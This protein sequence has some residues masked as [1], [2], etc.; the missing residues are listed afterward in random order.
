[1]DEQ[2]AELLLEKTFKSSFDSDNF[3]LF[4]KELFNKFD[5]SK[6]DAE[7]EEIPKDFQE[8]IESYS[9][10]G[11][12][13][14]Q[15]K[16]F[17][18][19][20]AVKLKK[21]NPE[22]ARTMQRNFVAKYLEHRNANAALVAFYGDEIDNWRFSFVKLEYHLEK[23]EKGNVKP[24][25]SLTPPKRYSFLVGKTESSHT[26]QS[27]FLELLMKE[28]SSLTVSE[29][30][31]SFSVEKVT[32]EFFEKYKELFLE[33]E[34][35]LNK[36]VKQNKDLAREFNE[37]GIS[38]IDFTKK[39]LGQI[40]FIYFLQKKGWLG[41]EKDETGKFRE[42]GTG[43]KDFLKKLYNKNIVSYNNFFNDI[44]EPLFYEALARDRSIDDDYYGKFRCKIPFLNG[45][46]FE[47]VGGYNW[48]DTDILLDN[49]IFGRIIEIFDLYNFTVKEDEPLEKEVAI[50]PEM[51]G[52]VFENLLEVKDRKSKGSYYTPREIVYYM[53]QE[54]LINY[55][56]TKTEIDKKHIEDFI[57]NGEV[58][59]QIRDAKEKVDLSLKN[60]KVVDPA[61]G[62][63]AFP[64]GMMMEIIKA[65]GVLT[66]LFPKEEQFERTA[67]NFKRECIE[68]NLYG[69]DIDP[70][71]VDIAQLRL[72]LSLIV[73]E[74]DI[75][76]IKPLPNLD[77]KIM[78]GNS[79]LDEFEGVKLFDERL[80]GEIKKE[81]YSEEIRKIEKDIGK[82][83]EELGMIA[84]G[85]KKDY[86]MSKG[87]KREIDKLKKKKQKLM[88]TPQKEGVNRDL[89]EIKKIKE[90]QKKL[91]EIKE[92][93]KL[94]FNEHDRQK[95]IELRKEIEKRD[96]E[97]IEETLKE[98]GNEDAMKKLEQVKKT[99]S[100]PFFLWKLYF[101]DVFQEKGG[102]DVVIANPPY[103][104]TID[105]YTEIFERL[106]PRTTKEFK[107]IY[108]IFIDKSLS[109]LTRKEGILT[110]IV[111]NTFLL[112]PRYKDLR[113]FLLNFD[114]KVLLNLGEDVFEA[115]VPTA[116]I[117]VK[118]SVSDKNIIYFGDLSVES[119]FLGDINNI[120][121]LHISQKEYF[122]VKNYLF[123]SS[124]RPLKKD[125]Y[126]L[127][128]IVDFKDAGINY[129]RVNV[130][131]GDKGNSDL[132]QRLLYEGKKEDREDVM[133][134]KG[135]DINEFYISPFT[136][137][138]V[139]LQTIKN[140]RENERVILNKDYFKLKPKLLW[141]QTAE[142][143]IVAI[144]EQG[145]WFGRS[146]QSAIIKKSFVKEIDYKYLLGLLNSKYIR[147]LYVQS[148]KEMGRVFPQVKL[149]KLAYL[150]IKKPL[151]EVQKQFIYLVSQI[152]F[153]TK[154]NNYLNSTDGQTKVKKLKN[155]ID[156]LVYKL[157]DL[158]KEEIGVVENLYKKEME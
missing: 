34:E 87:I 15:E 122:N 109:E 118:K 10:F 71:A 32:K 148:V 121:F 49:E 110:Y 77:Y 90:S 4:I 54:S 65:R 75:H 11:R 55:L 150:P 47:P 132:G 84:T 98:Q 26:A 141:R 67:Y 113:Q 88:A 42:W 154:E 68:N 112:Q 60:I 48:A 151:S 57:R 138:F 130:G 149:E 56:E 81:D 114:I 43:H 76:K 73:D 45:G 157:Y 156:Q 6:I 120:N 117:I 105:D 2:R 136:N 82:L 21:S 146:I 78:C 107:D 14:D 108:K 29:I 115:A 61:I 133:Y 63:G 102:F 58:S 152:L 18:E 153:I 30:E 97:F 1:M 12:Y 74:E 142:F 37:K 9:L 145:L 16:K 53:C 24:S 92:L 40:V 23:D 137:R 95:K 51:L 83:Y 104:A 5:Y 89:F 147:F 27:R 119:K 3:V 36:I 93:H 70:G 33:L 25:T 52:K 99:R 69:V 46:L 100:K 80:L 144:D 66:K 96:W 103:G 139:R 44:L 20:L 72:W 128:S 123:V 158:T 85:K 94:F 134:W 106:Y 124:F 19:V 140:L 31:S 13:E 101:S 50:D 17:I 126:Y 41:I 35:S 64:V 38:T 22:S 39:L 111:P 135:T 28:D 125:E 127:E 131:L 143:P 155:E 8:F 129:Q 116:I 86:G 59:A 79:L 62:S 91:K 7:Q